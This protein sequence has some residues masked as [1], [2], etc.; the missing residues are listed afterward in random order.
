VGRRSTRDAAYPYLLNVPAA[1]VLAVVVGVP[2]VQ[3][4]WMAMTDYDFF[5]DP[6][7]VGFTNF[8]QLATADRA[9]W[10]VVGNTVVWTVV[11]LVLEFGFALVTALLLTKVVRWSPLWRAIALLP[12]VV[13]P[14]TAGLVWKTMLDSESGVINAILTGLGLPA[15][16]FLSS[17]DQAMLTLIVVAVWR[18][19]PFMIISL[20]AGIQSIDRELYEAS[21]LDGARPL[22][23]FR[24]VTWPLLRPV[25]LVVLAMGAIWRSGHFDLVQMLTGGG[26]AGSTELLATYSYRATI[27]Q[28]DGG[29]GAAIALVT[30]FVTLL[31]GGPVFRRLVR[32]RGVR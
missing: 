14:V 26:P 30:L 11:S 18:Y 9:F 20:L 19:S 13:P 22:Q 2:L 24:H 21:A 17:P 1:L 27:E 7:F 15:Q 5:S 31:V 3:V 12:W 29:A 23:Q 4:V 28:L 16:P 25:V 10:R 8:V 6:S 32:E